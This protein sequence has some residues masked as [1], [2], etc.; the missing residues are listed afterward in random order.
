[1]TKLSCECCGKEYKRKINLDKHFVL[2]EIVHK[3]KRKDKRTDKEAEEFL[4]SHFP[5]YVHLYHRL[6]RPQYKSDLIRYLWLYQNG[7]YYIDI[8]ILPILPLWT[9]YEKT[10]NSDCFFAIG[11]YTNPQKGPLEISNGFIAS[12]HKNSI[13]ILI[14][15]YVFFLTFIGLRVTL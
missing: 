8:D 5:Q 1:M 7:G 2:C 12:A 4:Q 3:A 11:A 14:N 6:T 13:C 15:F 10:E 9:I